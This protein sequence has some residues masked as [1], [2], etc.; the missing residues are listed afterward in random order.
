L[1][2]GATLEQLAD[3]TDMELGTIDYFAGTEDPMASYPEFQTAA[4]ALTA[5][6]FPEAIG[7]SD[8][9]MVAMRLDAVKPPELIPLDKVQD[10]VIAAWTADETQARLTARAE[11]IKAA[12]AAGTPEAAGV[13]LT[14][15]DPMKRDG[16]VD[17]APA[18]LLETLFKLAEG[19]SQIIDEPGKVTVVTLTKIIPADTLPPADGTDAAKLRSAIAEQLSRS[20]A[21]DLFDLYATALQTEAGIHLDEAAIGA[22]EAQMQ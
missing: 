1:A 2:G 20:L 22:V 9:G 7:L 4:D 5:D 6:A 19:E 12:L 8:G 16:T 15:V 21:G 14:L 13:T 10:D 3:E 11:E 18:T 17:G